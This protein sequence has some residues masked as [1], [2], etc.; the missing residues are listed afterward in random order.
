MA[1]KHGGIDATIGTV[2]VLLA[3]VAVVGTT[4][5]AI[6]RGTSSEL[7]KALVT[8]AIAL[9]VSV[10][11]LGVSKSYEVNAAI[12]KDLRERKV[13]I[14]EEIVKGLY[15]NLFAEKL[16]E[17]KPTEQEQMAFIAKTTERL[18]IWGSDE[19]VDAWARVRANTLSN[20]DEHFI[21]LMEVLLF[22]LRKD[23]GHKNRRMTRGAILR[24]LVNDLD[25]GDLST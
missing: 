13:P 17:P 19:V 5:W 8:P 6:F 25:E 20:K 16:G 14:Y 2:L 18:T 12:K 21:F 3:I 11:T 15:A 1:A 9:V 4:G 7:S 22:A 10:I 24:L 23:L